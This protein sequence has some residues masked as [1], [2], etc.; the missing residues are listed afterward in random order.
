MLGKK[1]ELQQAE[2][3]LNLELKIA[4][5][6]GRE[7]VFTRLE[8]EEN[9]NSPKRDDAFI[10]FSSEMKRANHSCLTASPSGVTYGKAKAGMLHLHR[11]SPEFYY[12]AIPKEVKTEVKKEA[13]TSQRSEEDLL[14]EIF[15]V[16]YKQLQTMTLSQK[17]LATAVSLPQPEV[18]KFTGDPTK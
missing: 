7:R 8:R 16:Q 18:Q 17:Q 4:K 10:E 12:R 1:F 9:D 2:E 14:K 3:Q 6:Q 11:A 15:K 5:S 13:N